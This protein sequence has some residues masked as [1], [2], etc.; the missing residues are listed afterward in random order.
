M[1]SVAAELLQRSR[2]HAQAGGRGTDVARPRY[3]LYRGRN[4]DRRASA[5]RGPP[6]TLGAARVIAA[7]PASGGQDDRLAGEVI[8]LSRAGPA[9][10]LPAL[11]RVRSDRPTAGAVRAEAGRTA[12]SALPQSVTGTHPP[13]SGGPEDAARAGNPGEHSM[14]ASSRGKSSA[15]E[16]IETLLGEELTTRETRR[17][18]MALMTARLTTIKTLGQL[19]LQLPTLA[20]SQPGAG[21]GPTRLHR[22][23]TMR[24]FPGP[25]GNG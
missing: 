17:I 4:V 14:P 2:R 22:A 21:P 16:A 6:S 9:R 15:L 8:A 10:R 20:R 5:A 25:A 12:M 13:P 11:D 18:K 3:G 23:A 19:R 1:V 24:A 7:R